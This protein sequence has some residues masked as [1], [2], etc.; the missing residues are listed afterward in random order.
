[1]Y[2]KKHWQSF[3]CLACVF[4]AMPTVAKPISY[5]GG[6]M[7]MVESDYTGTSVSADYTFSPRFA[8]ALYAKRERHETEFTMVGPQLNV[9]LQR[10]NLPDGQGNIFAMT[11]TGVAVEGSHNR[12]AAWTSVL[13]DYETRR[14]FSSYE[15][16]LM[17]VRGE[18]T[19]TW[20]RARLGVAPYLAN[21]DDLNTWFMVQVDH[22]PE[23]RRAITATPLVRLFYKTLLLEGGVSTHGDVMLNLVKQF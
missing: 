12:Y 4:V 14:I 10:W 11:G 22:H 18:A 23:K 19:S 15:V 9:L 20:Q 16:R 3:A 2:T 21:Y 8:A 5:V 7:L 1:M 6:T 13:A 17:Y